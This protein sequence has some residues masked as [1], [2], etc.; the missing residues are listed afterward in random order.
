MFAIYFGTLMQVYMLFF[1]TMRKVLKNYNSFFINAAP[2][3]E[4]G[5]GK[6]K[7]FQFNDYC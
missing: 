4:G 5:G 6:H 1:E 3:E 2:V 7:P